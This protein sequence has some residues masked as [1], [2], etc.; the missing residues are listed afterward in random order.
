MNWI[1]IQFNSKEG[2]GVDSRLMDVFLCLG[3]VGSLSCGFFFFFFHL[4]RMEIGKY[5][6]FRWLS[7]VVVGADSGWMG[8]CGFQDEMV[9][10]VNEIGG[11]HSCLWRQRQKWIVSSIDFSG[12]EW[13]WFEGY[14][15][16]EGEG[17]DVGD[18]EYIFFLA[19]LEWRK[20]EMVERGRGNGGGAKAVMTMMAWTTTMLWLEF[21]KNFWA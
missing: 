16:Y 4:W 18:R 14:V 7:L 21:F 19:K 6:V 1:L 17:S 10:F 9:G 3:V 15:K 13:W 8:I 2:V 5:G 12:R 11:L 20:R